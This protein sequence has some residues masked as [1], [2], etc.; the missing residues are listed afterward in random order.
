M[1]IHLDRIAEEPFDWQETLEVQAG[2]L[3][4]EEVVGLSPIACRGQVRSTSTGHLLRA[5]LSYR[6]TLQCPRCL[7]PT[8]LPVENEIGLLIQVR[9]EPEDAPKERELEPEDLGVLVIPQ[10]RLDTRPIV[11]EQ[12]HLG[13]PMK[14]LCRD[15]CAGLCTTCGQNLNEGLCDC[16]ERDVD[17]R[18]RALTEL[19]RR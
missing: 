2:E 9:D 1:I 15:D 8:E 17:P 4:L 7:G 10:P 14:A 12:L 5:T 19:Q 11:I 13:V 6:Q 16:P 18:W 3:E